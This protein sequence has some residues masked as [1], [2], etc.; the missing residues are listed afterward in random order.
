M[1][2]S[3]KDVLTNATK[4][5]EADNPFLFRN[6]RTESVH[7]QLFYALLFLPKAFLEGEQLQAG[8]R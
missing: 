2:T 3:R 1:Q 6:V 5:D 8:P 4:V 7:I